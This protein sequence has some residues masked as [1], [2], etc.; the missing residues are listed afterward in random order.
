MKSMLSVKA[1]RIEH[2]CA[3]FSF[4]IILFPSFLSAQTAWTPA[5]SLNLPPDNYSFLATSPSGDLMV[6]TYNNMAATEAPADI[7]AIL[8]RNPTSEDPQIKHLCQVT[9]ASQRG[10]SGICC[11]Q[12]GFFYLSGDTGDAFSCFLRKFKPDGTPDTG[13]GTEGIVMP[14]RRCLGVDIVGNYLILAVDWGEIQVYNPSNGELLGTIRRP[15]ELHYVRDI[16]ID[17]T[18]MRIFGVAAGSVVMWEGGT[19]WEPDKYSFSALTP[20]SGIV[21]SGEGISID[22]IARSALVMPIRG[23]TLFEVRSKNEI[24]KT[25]IPE[26]RADGHIVDTAL[27]FDGT[28]LFLTD[29]LGKRILVMKR[30]LSVDSGR[31]EATSPVTPS[32]AVP[33][34]A[35]VNVSAAKPVE[36]Q[37][38]YMDVVERARREGKPMVVYFRKQ[39]VSKCDEVETNILLTPEFNSRAQGFYCVF[40]DLAQS[41]L[42]AHRLGVYRVPHIT[43]LDKKGETIARYTFRIT[44]EDLFAA[45]AKAGQ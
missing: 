28:T 45:I 25:I 39:G 19:P 14:R 38:S 26:A 35:P 22:P 21:R 20:P 42:T 29:I 8:I 27:S 5:G 44:A 1:R 11:D 2:L 4:M 34:P 36:W 33:S 30:S 23:N 41:T 10:Y 3:I 32:A 18:S 24:T 12:A 9:F 15:Q 16:A 13:F 37:K 43:I 7:P 31:I 6:T 40:E 17:P